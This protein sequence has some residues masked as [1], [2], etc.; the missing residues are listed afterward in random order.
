MR[1]SKLSLENFGPY[2]K[3]TIIDFASLGEFFLICGPTGSGKSTLFDAMTYSLFGQAP[4]GR[5]GFEAELVSDFAQPGDRPLVELEFFLSGS[6][7]R[8]LRQAPYRKPK[9]GGGF[10]EAPAAASLYVASRSAESGWKI[11]AEGVRPVNQKVTE[12]IGLSADEFSKIILLPQ[13]EFQKFLEMDS[14]KRS[15]VLEK[16]FPV[17]LYERITELAK[18]RTQEAKNS[19]AALDAELARLQTEL[20]E[21]PEAEHSRLKEDYGAARLAE[22]E[23]AASLGAAERRLEL[24]NKV[25]VKAQK[26]ERAAKAVSELLERTEAE[27]KRL[28]RIERAKAAAA[29]QP[30]SRGYS[31]ARDK[32]EE[33]RLKAGRM[34]EDL[35][36]LKSEAP[37]REQEAERVKL[38]ESE[39]A[40]DRRRL[41]GLEKALELWM[42]R[43]LALEGLS[44]AM[45]AQAAS[46]RR[47]AEEQLR[48]EGL[49][50][51]IESLRPAA[52]EEAAARTRV[53]ELREEK[54]KLSA[55]GEELARRL[56]LLEEKALL[57]ADLEALR[58]E[59][60]GAEARVLETE[61]KLARLEA[62][63]ALAEAGTLAAT[64]KPGKPCPVCGSLD[65]PAPALGWEKDGPSSIVALEEARKARIGAAAGVA[66]LDAKLA[67][68]G[69]RIARLDEDIAASGREAGRRAAAVSGIVAAFLPSLQPGSS[70]LNLGL[71]LTAMQTEETKDLMED[72]GLSIEEKERLLG[73]ARKRLVD[74]DQRREEGEAEELKFSQSLQRLE[75]LRSGAEVDRQSLA[76]C[77]NSLVEIEKESGSEDPRPAW[78]ALGSEV[79]MKEET[80]KRIE[81]GKKEWKEELAR[82]GARLETL[83]PEEK[84]AAHAL[85]RARKELSAALA[86]KGFIQT[87]KGVAEGA[88]GAVAAALAA[89][90]AAALP[91]T[92]LAAEER[93]ALAYR[94]AL[95]AARAAA[96]SEAAQLAEERRA[97][98]DEQI[99]PEALKAE[100]DTLRLARDDAR[101]RGE[102]LSLRIDRLQEALARRAV[103]AEARSKADEGSRGL[104][105]LSELLRGEISGRRLPFKNYVLAMYF[106]QVIRRAS[107]HLSKMSEGRYYLKPEEGQASGRGR[108][109]LGLRVLDSWTGQDRSSGTLSG[110]EKFLTSISLALGLADSL[111]EQRGAVSLESVF[112][113]EGFGSLDEE[114]LDRAIRV[115]D[116]IRGSRVIGIVSHVTELKTRIPA[117]I[118]VEKSSSGSSLRQYSGP[119]ADDA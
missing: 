88:K 66:S 80:L 62:E 41:Y 71:V 46:A 84:A 25:V 59:R 32:A 34:S 64:L 83:L 17:G 109:G 107:V 53:E 22:A 4:G 67:L 3:K 93:A 69:S 19:L 99:D 5:Q 70:V 33:L 13:G 50:Q 26:A 75:L 39:L 49:R 2:R 74:L 42:R 89:A 102:E 37:E 57:E 16:L 18:V 110:G 45:S 30:L 85:E 81:A 55:L 78:E 60:L 73:E 116:R 114:S 1:P 119:S 106:R 43:S 11:I 15:E 9:R 12:L 117:R 72:L 40:E 118:E 27:K 104:Y 103:L 87:E 28:A 58:T 20:G 95:A 112:I 35:A 76:V 6:L 14:T 111:R 65:H 48:V 113:D 51:R 77:R 100:I 94:E 7:Y 24:V 47:F 54:G 105:G 92:D 21:E 97:L 36:R 91:P 44:K 31:N 101:S 108:I 56:R 98:G 61:K 96:D 52:G 79:T 90:E 115:L 86:D 82:V 68:L 10:G 38:L 29:V 8:I 23:A 63:V